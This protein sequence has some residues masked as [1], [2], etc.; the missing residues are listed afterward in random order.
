MIC[1]KWKPRRST[2][3]HDLQR[4]D[5]DGASPCARFLVPCSEHKVRSEGKNGLE[6]RHHDKKYVPNVIMVETTLPPGEVDEVPTQITGQGRHGVRSTKGD[7]KHGKVGLGIYSC[8][9]LS[10]Q[11]E[12]HMRA[13]ER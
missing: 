2:Q 11:F 6:V 3:H 10:K 4:P 8:Q 13:M 1:V 7:P 5:H 12:K 9:P